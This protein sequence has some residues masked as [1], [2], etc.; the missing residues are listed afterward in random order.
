MHGGPCYSKAGLLGLPL[1]SP[2]G[3]CLLCVP[4]TGLEVEIGLCGEGQVWLGL[5]EAQS[6]GD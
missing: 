5:R 3:H 6:F 1:S 4:K 2:Q